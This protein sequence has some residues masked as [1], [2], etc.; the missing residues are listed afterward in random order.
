MAAVLTG[1]HKELVATESSQLHEHEPSVR[2]SLRPQVQAEWIREK[3][4]LVVQQTESRVG[5]AVID[6]L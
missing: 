6:V 3:H 1:Y 5:F 2:P 4:R